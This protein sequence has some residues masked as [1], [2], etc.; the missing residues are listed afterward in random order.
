MAQQLITASFVN[1]SGRATWLSPIII[2]STGGLVVENG[3][4]TEKD[5]YGN[6]EYTFVGYDKSKLYYFNIDGNN[7]EVFN[8]YQRKNNELDYYDNKADWWWQIRGALANIDI[9][10]SKTVAKEIKE[11]LVKEIL[12]RLDLI[13]PQDLTEL[14]DLLIEIK[15]KEPKIDLDDNFEEISNKI[16]E[17]NINKPSKDDIVAVISTLKSNEANLLRTNEANYKLIEK[18]T[19][20]TE[21]QSEMIEKLTEYIQKLMKRGN[22]TKDNDFKK[23]MKEVEDM[24][25]TIEQINDVTIEV[26]KMVEEKKT[27][28]YWQLIT[29]KES[30]ISDKT[31]Y[32]SGIDERIA[33]I[34]SYLAEFNVAE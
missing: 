3:I 22:L 15:N 6:Y 19:N 11:L 2:I 30:L 26:T 5:A 9:N 10:I 1:S 33:K 28:T 20:Q 27:F 32:C 31:N 13:Q 29:E 21:I 18:L 23:L 16:D 12:N 17:T 14:K 8:R 25:E 7:E 24:E 4:M 34:D